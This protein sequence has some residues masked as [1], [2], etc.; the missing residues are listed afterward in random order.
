MVIWGAAKLA[1]CPPLL[2]VVIV[3]FSKLWFLDRMVWLYEEMKDKEPEY[4]RWLY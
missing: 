4:K 3:Y 2:G 1:I